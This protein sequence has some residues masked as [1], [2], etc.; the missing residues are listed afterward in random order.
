MAV[1]PVNELYSLNLWFIMVSKFRC[2]LE[3]RKGQCNKDSCNLTVWWCNTNGTLW[4]P[5][6]QND[7]GHKESS[8]RHLSGVILDG[9]ALKKLNC[10]MMVTWWVIGF[11]TWTN[12]CF[13]WC[14][15]SSNLDLFISFWM[16]TIM[17]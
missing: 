13:S 6:L 7:L 5:D 4:A 11:W 3:R 8:Q 10:D 17:S 12:F 15:K 14:W 2:L 16:Y 9:A 1:R